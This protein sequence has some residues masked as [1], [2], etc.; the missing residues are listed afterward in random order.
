M[1]SIAERI[2]DNEVANLTD[3]DWRT[4]TKFDI[5]ITAEV[6]RAIDSREVKLAAMECIERQFR[7]F[8]SGDVFMDIGSNYLEGLKALKEEVTNR[9][10]Y[11]VSRLKRKK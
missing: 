7:I 5:Q 9:E 3:V 11:D 2:N 6:I 10:A 1:K 4:E 8:K